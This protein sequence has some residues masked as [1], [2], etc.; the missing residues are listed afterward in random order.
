MCRAVMSKYL[1]GQSAANQ[2]Q[3]YY[4]H[5]SALVGDLTDI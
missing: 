4:S 2:A 3:L 1:S 5:M